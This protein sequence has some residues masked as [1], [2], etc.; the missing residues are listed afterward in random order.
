MR[1]EL[2]R[3]SLD[4][5]LLMKLRDCCGW[6]KKPKRALAAKR[7]YDLSFE[8]HAARSAASSAVEFV[9]LFH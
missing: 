3:C 8:W 7:I 5:A 1:N 6:Q 4:L 9:S 2:S